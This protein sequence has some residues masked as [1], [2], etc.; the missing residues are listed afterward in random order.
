MP[1]GQKSDRPL[2]SPREARIP[3][4]TSKEINEWAQEFLATVAADP[5]AR[6][7]WQKL[8][9]AGLDRSALYPLWKYAHSDAVFERL[10]KD[11]KREANQVRDTIRALRMAK[12]GQKPKRAKDASIFYRRA[13]EHLTKLDQPLDWPFLWEDESPLAMHDKISKGV[14]SPLSLELLE[15]HFKWL[16]GRSGTLR[17]EAWLRKLQEF[18]AKGGVMLGLKALVAIAE[19]AAPPISVNQ[20]TLSRIFRRWAARS[21]TLHLK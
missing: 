4:S 2:Q 17:P 6:H 8:C 16:S 11:A 19:C 5:T 21:P 15:G 9:E 10:R 7:A 3:G 13:L 1:E 18:A 14:G 20:S 12:S